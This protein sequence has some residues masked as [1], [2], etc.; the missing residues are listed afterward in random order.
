M[1]ATLKSAY[2]LSPGKRALLEALLRK[3]GLGHSAEARILRRDER[4]AAPLSF[5]QQRL[6][7][8]EQLDPGTALYNIP[9]AFRLKGP[10]DAAAL[11][12]S[13]NQIIRRH[14]T[15]R[16]GVVTREGGAHAV[17]QAEATVPFARVDLQDLPASRRES[18]AMWLAR[19]EA[20]RPFALSEA[21]LLRA[22][23]L[24]LADDDHMVV[25][26]MHHIASDGWSIE[27]LARELLM[28]MRACETGE[29]SP[30]PELPI[31]YGDFAAWQ[32]EWMSG[33]RLEAELSYWKA[34]LEGAPA[35]LEIPTDRPRGAVQDWRGERHPVTFGPELTH[36]L[37]TLA[38]RERATLFMLLLAAF[39]VL[40]F[41]YSRQEDLVVGSPVANRNRAEIEHL[42]GFFVNMLP[43][44]ARLSGEMSFRELLAQVRETAL[45]AFAHQDLPF[46]KLVDEL[47]AGRDTAHAPL[48]QAVFVLQTA[49]SDLASLAGLPISI[50]NLETGAAKFDLTLDLT[51]SPEGLKGWF[52]YRTQLFDRETM[53][54]MERHLRTLLEAIA[55]SPDCSVAQLPL[56]DTEERSRLVKQA[57][58]C[59][60]VTECI[61]HRFERIARRT[62]EAPA[63]TFEGRSLTY[64]ELDHRANQLAQKLKAF[65]VGPEVRVGMCVERSVEMVV[66]ILAVLK[67]GGAYVPLDP[68]C[69]AERVAF[70]LED[71]R[72][73]VLLTEKPRLHQL[74]NQPARILC[75]DDLAE[76]RPEEAEPVECALAPANAAYVIYTSGSTGKPKGVVVDHAN[77]LRLLDSTDHWFQFGEH[78]V[79]TLFHSYAFDFS[80]WEIWGA[81]LYGGRLVVVPYWV[82]RSPEAFYGL[83]TAEG[84]TVLNQTPSAFR[85]LI[86]AEE[87]IGVAPDLK[88]RFVI[89]GGEA[90]E[91][92]SLRP[93]FAR[94]G[95]QKPRLVNMYGITETTV[96]VTYRPLDA[97]D[98]RLAGRS[99]IGEPIPDLTLYVLDPW[100]EPVPVGVPG[101]MYVGGAGVARGYL[102]RPELTAQRFVP[103][104]FAATPGERLYRSGDLARYLAGG[105]L[106][107]LGRI[108]DQVKIRGFRIELGEIESVL[109]RHPRIRE[110]VVMSRE[111]TAGEARLAAYVVPREE[112]APSAGELRAF[113]KE[114]LPEYM[115]PAAI[116]TLPALPLTANGKVDRRALPSPQSERRDLE[117]AYAAPRT[118]AERVLAEIWAQVLGL[119]QVGVND[120]FFEL[121]GDSILSIQ[122][123]ASANQ[124][125]LRLTP[126]QLFQ[127]QTVAALAQAAEASSAKAASHHRVAGPVPLTPI[128]HWFF[129]QNLPD[130]HH[131]NQ[132][133]ML[134]ARARVRFDALR[135]AFKHV[136]EHHDS[137]RLRFEQDQHAWRQRLV[138]EAAAPI[139][140]FDFGAVA[141]AERDHET[142]RIAAELQSGLDITCGPVIRAA[143]FGSG[144]DSTRLVIVAHHLVI[145]AVSWRILIED[146]E[147]AYAQICATGE[148][149]LAPATLPFANWAS[150]L[151]Q[152][153]ASPRILGELAY[154][155]RQEPHENDRIPFDFAEGAN[156]EGS[157]ETVSIALSEEE[158]RQVLQELPRA[159]RTQI[160]DALLAALLDAY[161][162]WSSRRSLVVNLEGHGREPISGSPE[163][164]DADLSRT[165][166]WFTALFPVRL[167]LPGRPGP[168]EL[169]KAVKEQLRAVPARGIGYGLLRYLRSTGEIVTGMDISFNYLGRLDT[170]SS[171]A[172]LFAM[173]NED[174]GPV[175]DPAAARAHAIDIVGFVRENRLRINW[176]FSTALHR[177]S[178]IEALAGRFI[179]ALRGLIAHCLSTDAGG[180]TP[181]DFPRARVRQR[182]LDKLL[183]KVA[184]QGKR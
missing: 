128:Q 164:E 123:I 161:A 6:W 100:L 87:A 63:I 8:L 77:V 53:A 46:E 15:L 95:D 173:T 107:Y 170:A 147:T 108:D 24:D 49:T 78:D 175:H 55:A 140:S 52:E 119:P 20:C 36:A 80:V 118:E 98:L 101:E 94:H 166:G 115:V 64:R 86:Q 91:L 5:A 2:D 174:C 144:A 72:A 183:A 150:G 82:S 156:T 112:P 131:W 22:L 96:H 103:N 139:E 99:V 135:Q 110:A 70:I 26:A 29:S 7:F 68:N 157:A 71:S 76:P 12:R 83:L 134:E 181:S 1:N 14:E 126:R 84:V 65:G 47:K 66:G 27:I 132:A 151:E 44:R 74:E 67:A 148:V 54:R 127:H 169:L 35:L 130:P 163:L 69:P 158:T 75:L 33:E 160:N 51:E 41:R 90:L 180:F 168:G 43:L 10:L 182:D 184:Q 172:A 136:I 34:A 39:Q 11:E 159:Y 176:I 57:V 138:E 56:L 60:P 120:N 13:L 92:E 154:W 102:E 116:V 143:L 165:T 85:Q 58:A 104:P 19:E 141:E 79:W 171:S 38:E 62:P 146:L 155:Q 16:S 9:A 121:G 105:E 23:V 73:P 88:L 129:S 37:K 21:P 18:E 152:Y 117:G 145:D 124:A 137:F 48:F 113:L 17:V 111:D 93:W 25:L 89:F 28:L 59:V 45:G 142:R 106:E 133:V 30:L 109:A 32:R 162:G 97:G 81:L 114:H 177:R 61:H 122:I 149:R 179:Q 3:K 40:L 153:A 50:V 178:T 125:G 42:I 31:Q 4:Q 167:D